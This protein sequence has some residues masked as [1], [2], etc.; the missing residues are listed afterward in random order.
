MEGLR[1]PF[2]TMSAERLSMEQRREGGPYLGT[3]R[4]AKVCFT[5]GDLFVYPATRK[6]STT[7][8]A[9]FPFIC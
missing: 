8:L 1:L 9:K 4:S 7:L 6:L 2:R 5:E 3:L